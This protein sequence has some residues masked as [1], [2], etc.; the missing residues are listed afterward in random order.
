M[1]IQKFPLTTIQ[2]I[3]QY[4]SSTLDIADSDPSALSADYAS[5]DEVPEPESLD[6]LSGLFTFGGT[7][8]LDIMPSSPREQWVI[9]TVN[10]GAALLKLPGLQLKSNYRLVSYLYR[11]DEGRVGVIWAVPVDLSTTAQLEKA[12]KTSKTISQIPKPDGALGNFMDA[13]EGDRSSASF[14]VASMLR[15]ELQE[16]GATG[17]RR[18]W[19]HHRL[20]DAVPAKVNWKWRVEQT[21][22]LSPKVKR[23][24]DDQAIVEYFTCRIVAPVAIYRHVDQY[25]PGQYRPNSI[26]QA[27]AIAHR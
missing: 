23:S 17:K 26:D 24:A 14:L 7:S 9:S 8:D 20:I 21:P 4:I 19:T 25:A 15:R 16:F 2:K 27:V 5:E 10:P 13:I 12:L 6:D 11:S 1:S 22:D 18:N 3:R